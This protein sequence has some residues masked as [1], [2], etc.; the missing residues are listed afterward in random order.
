MPVLH[1]LPLGVYAE[2]VGIRMV[3]FEVTIPL[4]P[5]DYR[6]VSTTLAYTEA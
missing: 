4:L 6:P 2:E 3:D 5:L 1:G